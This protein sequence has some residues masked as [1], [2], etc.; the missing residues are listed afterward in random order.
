[1]GEAAYG[2]AGGWGQAPAGGRDYGDS[3]ADSQRRGASQNYGY[4]PEAAGWEG[5]PGYEQGFAGDD[6]VGPPS[7]VFAKL[8]RI[9]GF[10]H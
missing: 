7:G 8:K 9:L 1:M 5:G 2:P 6:E 10:G 4:R 3:S